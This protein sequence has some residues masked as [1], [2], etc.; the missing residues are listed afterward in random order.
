MA[1]T[2]LE[3]FRPQ[4]AQQEVADEQDPDDDPQDVGH[5]QSLSQAWA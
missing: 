2:P 3:L 5:G 1:I 4:D